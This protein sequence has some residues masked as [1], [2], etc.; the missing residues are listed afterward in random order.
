M[1]RCR[2]ESCNVSFTPLHSRQRFC[3]PD[4]NVQWQQ[5]EAKRLRAE[6]RAA[7]GRAPIVNRTPSGYK[8]RASASVLTPEDLQQL[9]I[10][11]EIDEKYAA[12][13]DPGRRIQGEEFERLAEY[14]SQQHR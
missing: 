5:D 3:C 2:L 9:R 1:I 8:P 14:Y 4:H 12:G 13:G 6:A 10:N 11:Q 7:S